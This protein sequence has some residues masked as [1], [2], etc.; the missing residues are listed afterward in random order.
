MKDCNPL[1]LLNDSFSWILGWL[2]FSIFWAGAVDWKIFRAKTAEKFSSGTIHDIISPRKTLVDFF[3]PIDGK[4][5]LLL[6]RVR[7]GKLLNVIIFHSILWPG[8]QKWFAIL[9]K[10]YNARG[11]V[12][13]N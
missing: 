13:S 1:P 10:M 12:Q 3:S 7:L 11:E 6:D 8:F 4:R 2:I 9:G 5:W